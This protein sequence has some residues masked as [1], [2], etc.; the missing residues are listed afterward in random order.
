MGDRL[1][2]IWTGT[3]R[4]A[5]HR[6]DHRVAIRAAF[7]VA[8]PLILLW[9]LGRLDLS[10]YAT[11]GAFAA[12][13]GRFDRYPDR[14]RMQLAAGAV[15]VAAMLA[16]T[17]LAVSGA[18]AVVPVLVVAVIAAAVTALA[19]AARWHPPGALFAVFAAGATA[20]LPPSALGFVEVLAV[21]GGSALFSVLVTAV[22]AVA[23]RGPRAL[24][25][26]SAA[27]PS[28]VS[29][30]IPAS[31]GIGAALAG[32]AGLA[33]LGTHW[34]WA[35]VAAVAAL[36]GPH[37]N[38]RIA[39]GVQRLA[40]TLAGVL[41]AAGLLALH[42]PPLATIAVAVLCQ[43]GAELFINRNYG[44]AMLFVTP[45]ALLMIELAVPA[46]P[47]QLLRDRVLDTVIGVVVGTG[48]AVVSA[49]IRRGRAA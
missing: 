25:R 46:D 47:A 4:I 38:A 44:I 33:I 48:V 9:A 20:T 6:G 7:S 30:A 39:R 42:L 12:I 35:M 14:V 22:V 21:G 36:G 11:F 40:G 8:V 23:R 15:M 28:T 13:Y 43:V 5:P 3:I 18:P 24:A 27:G 31:V 17:A 32:L 37:V 45:L 26:S 16:G 41:V 10:V 34:Y 29:W 2:R 49:A 19:Q 1:Q